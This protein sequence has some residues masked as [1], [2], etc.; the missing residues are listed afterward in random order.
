MKRPIARIIRRAIG[1]LLAALGLV[2]VFHGVQL[3]RLMVS[4]RTMNWWWLVPA[5]LCDV[6]SY[7]CQGIRWTYLLRPVGPLSAF[8]A[9][10]AIYVGLF[11]N[12][13]VPMRVG[14]LVRAYLAGRWMGAPFASIVPSILVERLLDGVWLALGIGAAAL[15]IP[16]PPRVLHGAHIFG[17]A[18]MGAVLVFAV[19]LARN[20]KGLTAQE[21]A[22]AS[23]FR[24]WDSL[25]AF[26]RSMAMETRRIG[27][28]RI[29]ILAGAFSLG[30][31]I[32]QALAFWFVMVAYGLTLPLTAGFAILLLVHLGTAI[33][34]APANIGSYQFF[35]V[36]GLTV[37]GVDKNTAAA[38]SVAVFL[39]LTLPLWVLGFAALSKTGTSLRAL[40]ADVRAHGP[41]RDM[42]P[43]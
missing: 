2:W 35:A 16:L 33:P 7:G 36:L 41:A 28:P 19:L 43:F 12:E 4:A 15:L 40:R 23:R 38:F 25:K 32:F 1:Y 34:N 27:N 39:I 31:L 14:E 26:L 21:P 5:V 17:V 11:T 18:I 3:D 24:W 29:L 37:F 6:L 13:V 10:Q 22:T 30:L 9:T 20:P 8:R 42:K